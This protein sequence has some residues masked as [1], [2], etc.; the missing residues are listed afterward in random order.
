MMMHLTYNNNKNKLS[1]RTN[2]L[3][4]LTIILVVQFSYTTVATESCKAKDG[5]NL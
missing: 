1:K 5:K 4:A 2:Y 3:V